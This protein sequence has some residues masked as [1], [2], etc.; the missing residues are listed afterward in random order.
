MSA[1]AHGVVV[2]GVNSGATAYWP[3]LANYRVGNGFHSILGRL[4][5]GSGWLANAFIGAGGGG[6]VRDTKAL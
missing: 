4:K 5:V 3:P 6:G 1:R 2:V